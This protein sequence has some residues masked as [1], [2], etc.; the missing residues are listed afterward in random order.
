MKHF[1]HGLTHAAGLQRSYLDD[2]KSVS[3]SQ[4]F[5][6]LVWAFSPV[7]ALQ[8]AFRTGFFKL[9]DEF[10]AKVSKQTTEKIVDDVIAEINKVPKINQIPQDKIDAFKA[11][12]IKYLNGD[13]GGLNE[14][15]GALEKPVWSI[16]STVGIT[17][18]QVAP[19]RVWDD[20]NVTRI[21]NF[22]TTQ[23][24]QYEK[25]KPDPQ[26]SDLKFGLAGTAI[27]SVFIQGP[28][29]Y[30]VVY[31]LQQGISLLGLDNTATLGIFAATSAFTGLLLGSGRGKSGIASG[32]AVGTTAFA[33]QHFTLP[34]LVNAMSGVQLQYLHLLCAA[35]TVM[36]TLGIEATAQ[37]TARWND[38]DYTNRVKCKTEYPMHYALGKMLGFGKITCVKVA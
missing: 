33:M 27:V 28:A 3:I 26:V 36:A 13:A 31:G 21:I 11:P 20:A 10:S 19:P 9:A 8:D 5:I 14:L 18:S 6:R 24:E 4:S 25:K 22:L 35:M 16:N 7:H 38:D 17:S 29:I 32:I 15:K 23:K 12:I 30:A 1:F 34:E 37:T 2:A